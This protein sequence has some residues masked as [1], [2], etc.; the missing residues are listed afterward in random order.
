MHILIF[1]YWFCSGQ[2]YCNVGKWALFRPMKYRFVE[3]RNTIFSQVE[4]YVVFMK[5]NV[6]VNV[7]YTQ[8]EKRNTERCLIF[9]SCLISQLSST[10]CDFLSLT[11]D[12]I[13]WAA[14]HAAIYAL[15]CVQVTWKTVLI[16]APTSMLS[17][18]T[19]AIQWFY[20]RGDRSLL[21]YTSKVGTY[22]SK[23]RWEPFG[24]TENVALEEAFMNRESLVG[25]WE[26]D[27]RLQI[28][29]RW[30]KF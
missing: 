17:P 2:N 16:L 18:S 13:R 15:F 26:W 10:L 3:L 23:I 30:W 11:V 24:E 27:G 9:P 4:S 28:T 20:K 19:A 25:M 6:D 21:F 29:H 22:S 14:R 5:R 7:S 8:R 12:R 1:C